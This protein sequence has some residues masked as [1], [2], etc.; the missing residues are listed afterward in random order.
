M[1]TWGPI[2]GWAARLLL[3]VAAMAMSASAHAADTGSVSGV[4]FDRSGQ[5]AAEVV[6]TISGNR[7]PVRRTVQTDANGL[8]V[9]EYLLPGEYVLEFVKEGVGS[10]TRMALIEVGRDTQ[11]DLVLGLT[12]EEAVLVR[13]TVPLVDVR[14]TEVA[15][16]FGAETV[17]SLPLERTYQGLFQ[18]IPGVGDNRSPVGPAAGGSRQDNTYL[19]DGASIGNP[20]FGHLATDVNQLDILEVNLKRA[21]ISAEFGRSAGS[22]INAVS[23]SGTN[24]LRGV[25]RL[26]WLPA[27]FVGKYRL[28]PELLAAGI[29]PGAFRDQLLT[30]DA[31]AAFGI[32]GPILVD[33]AFFYGSARYLRRT[34]WER[35][36]KVGTLLPDEVR[37]A[38]E[39][40]GK[41]NVL[42]TPSHHVTASYR[43]RPGHVDN[44]ALSSDVAPTVAVT[45]DNGSRVATAQWTSFLSA[46]RSVDVKYLHYTEHNEDVPVRDLGYLPPFDPTRLADMGQYT[47]PGQANLIVGANQLTNIQNYRRTELRGTYTEL[48]QISRTS[49]MLKAGAAFE[50]GEERFNRVANGWGAIANVTLN[51]VPALRARYFTPQA[52]QIGQGHTYSLFLQDEMTVQRIAVNAGVLLNRDDFAQHL[53]GSGGCPAA[54]ALKGGTA[55]YESSGDTCTFMR[56]GFG[57]EIQPR[58]GVSYQLREGAG[59]KA[60]ANWGR[61]FNMDQKSS[62][63][64]L[65]PN[66]IFQTQTI[67]DLAGNVLSTAPL[68]STTR[69][70]IDPELKPIYTDEWLIGYATPVGGVYS[71]DVFFMSRDMNNVIEDIPS[72]MDGT[73]PDSG[74]YVAANLPCRAFAACRHA[75]ARRTYRA[76]TVD[77]RRRLTN[78]WLMEANYTWS[79]FDGNYDLDYSTVA[80]FNTSSIVQ[81][82]PGTDVEDPNRFGPL[83]EDRPHVL[84]VF[85]SY[86]ATPALS[87]SGYLRVQ[88]GT[89]WAA[90]GRDAAGAV[91]NYLEP[92]GA[93]RNPPWT[94]LDLMGTY[95]LPLQ[96]VRLA[97][98]AR[99][100]NIFDNQTRLSTDA[101]QFLDLRTTQVPPYIE[102]YRDPNPLFGTGNGFAP[103]RRLSLAATF[104]F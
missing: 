33:R 23:R 64:S 41:A 47:D 90:R 67:F 7:P 68:A 54:I 18:L 51:G 9:F 86:A 85:A 1:G 61:Y 35:S 14:S 91:L 16:N 53:E 40:Y 26:D 29:R 97:L 24:E 69:K 104:E 71:I 102:P 2:R 103:P 17:K 3:T 28:P 15:F 20:G 42:V 30:A 31:G 8:Y 13:A 44:A 10:T 94:N 59:D 66:R 32:G 82:A 81:D 101:Q 74:P 57:D 72:R 88:S 48:L 34:K 76:L 39:F 52:P 12:V 38:S 56:F 100:M 46:Q 6:V 93:H 60:Y 11:V 89:P 84:K 87:V 4:V 5:P 19:I 55:V 43:H 36:N 62:G 50:V 21:G 75:D 73:A 49:H 25:A 96:R 65:A 80:V 45:T 98:E 58:V 83:F 79:R 77:V 37:L 78:G 95:R 63:R 92:A 22:V 27:E 99:V 70:L